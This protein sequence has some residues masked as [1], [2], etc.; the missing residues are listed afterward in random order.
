MRG[1][2]SISRATRFGRV[3]GYAG[4]ADSEICLL[5]QVETVETIDRIEEIAAVDGVDGL[6]VGPGDL[7]ATLGHPGEPGRPEVV[8]VIEDTI[9]R[10]VAAGKPAAILADPA[11]A[12]RCIALGTTF[13]AVGIDA[14]SSPGRRKSWRRTSGA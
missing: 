12:R 8:A 2:S 7:A 9:R 14:A 11:I 3:A 10:I 1:I 5:V 4:R 6:F 13:T